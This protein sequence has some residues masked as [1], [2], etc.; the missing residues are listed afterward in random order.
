MDRQA[1]IRWMVDA[2]TH[3]V[4]RMLQKAGV[5]QSDLDDEMQ[6]TFL[7]AARRVDDVEYGAERKFLARVAFNVAAHSRRDIARRREV[8]NDEPPEQIEALVTP[9]HLANRQQMRL[10]LG[11]IAGTMHESLRVVFTLHELEEM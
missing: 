10:L 9:E 11:S 4:A 3:F 1:R 5:P 6:R 2:N 8:F 7:I